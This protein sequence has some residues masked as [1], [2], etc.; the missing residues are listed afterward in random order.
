MA[1]HAGGRHREGESLAVALPAP[2][3]KLNSMPGILVR[4]TC[5]HLCSLGPPL[6]LLSSLLAGLM[7]STGLL[8]VACPDCKPTDGRVWVNC[9]QPAY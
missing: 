1:S 7:G 4:H 2:L 5:V 3:A 9:R 6:R 8:R